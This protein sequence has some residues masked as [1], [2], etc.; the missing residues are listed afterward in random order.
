MSRTR[1]PRDLEHTQGDPTSTPVWRLILQG[2]GLLVAAVAV[3]LGVTIP[4]VRQLLDPPARS[5]VDDHYGGFPRLL[6]Y[7]LLA[8]LCLPVTVLLA[9]ANWLGLKLFKHNY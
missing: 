5:P 1:A 2:A 4:L 9:F 8:P 3:Q 6:F 7:G